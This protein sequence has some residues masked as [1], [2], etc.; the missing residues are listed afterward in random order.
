M[1]PGVVDILMITYNRP[2][3][4]ALSLDRLLSTCDESAR[5]WLWH[6]GSDEETLRVVTRFREHPRVHQ[7]HH[8]AKNEKLRLATN[9]VLREGQG[10]FFAKVDDDCLV[11]PG[12]LDVL[13]SSHQDEPCLGAVSC[14]HFLESDFSSELAKP[15]MRTLSGGHRIMAH[16]WVGGSGFLLKRACIERAGIIGD[17]ETMT[18]YFMRIARLGWINGWYYPLLIQ[19]HMDDP[20]SP[21]TMLKSDEDLKRFMPLSAANFGSGTLAAWD[22]QLRRSAR[23]LQTSPSDPRYY[24][25]WRVKLR[26]VVA[27]ARGRLGLNGEGAG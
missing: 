4:S 19:D 15:K 9:W 13:R 12:W 1:K 5:V 10:E 11:P 18:T 23:Q 21:N 20:R 22:A 24:S 25:P 17:G 26:R 3:Y 14:W 27:R 6:N 8:S 2:A 16:P 7:F